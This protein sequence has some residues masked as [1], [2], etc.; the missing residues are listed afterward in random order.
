VTRP[1]KLLSGGGGSSR[2]PPIICASADAAH[3][4]ELDGAKILSRKRCN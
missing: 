1:R 4:G 2:R 3:G